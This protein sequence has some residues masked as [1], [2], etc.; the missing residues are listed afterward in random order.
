[1]TSLCTTSFFAFLAGGFL[2]L[3]HLLL[4]DLP[5]NDLLPTVGN[6]FLNCA[7]R[8]AFHISDTLYDNDQKEC[9]VS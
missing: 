9:K 3:T 7:H 2:P 6:K 8:C 1:M 5:P 4:D